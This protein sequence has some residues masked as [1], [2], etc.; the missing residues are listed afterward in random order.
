MH[1]KANINNKNDNKLS[2]HNSIYIIAKELFLMVTY[3][4]IESI[5]SNNLATN[6]Y[7]RIK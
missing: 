1:L 2:N 5:N 3:N 4:I 6:K 7:N